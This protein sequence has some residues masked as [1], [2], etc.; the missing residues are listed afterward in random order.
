MSGGSFDHLY[1]KDVEYL[2]RRPDDA[3]Q[4]MQ[5]ELADRGLDDIAADHRDFL[6]SLRHMRGLH[7]SNCNQLEAKAKT[8]RE[9]WRMIELN[10]SCDANDDQV[11]A[12]VI[13]Y[14]ASQWV[15]TP[16]TK[17]GACERW[18]AELERRGLSLWSH[19]RD[20]FALCEIGDAGPEPVTTFC[21]DP[22]ELILRHTANL[23]LD[24]EGEKA[25]P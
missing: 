13:A 6:S 19:G 17:G 11:E 9:L 23:V 8:L 25:A 20:G 16:T 14:R 10:A 7:E 15:R 18:L 22:R 12:A 24:E 21:V 4:N 2:I 5:R 3:L 1:T